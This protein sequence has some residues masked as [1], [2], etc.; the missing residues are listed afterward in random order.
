MF[1]LSGKSALVTGAS[2]GI[3]RAFCQRL[4]AR[5]K[6]IIAVARREDRLLELQQQL[7]DV[8][9]I[10][11]QADLATVEGVTR[12]TEAI[13]QKGPVDLLVNNAGISVFGS[14]TDADVGQ[15]LDHGPQ[16]GRGGRVQGHG[17]R[18]D[19]VDADLEKKGC[20]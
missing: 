5:C 4:A 1:D 6:R 11:V 16:V 18:L 3:G 20:W 14:Y 17:Q 7:P 9:L 19:F 13:R 8:E 2:S 15:Q 12:C 10:P